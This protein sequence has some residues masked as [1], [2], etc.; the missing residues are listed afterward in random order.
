MSEISGTPTRPPFIPKFFSTVTTAAN[1]VLEVGSLTDDV[2]SAGLTGH[3]SLN[4][5]LDIFHAT[6][7]TAGDANAF[8][9]AATGE[10]P[11]SIT[12]LMNGIKV[13]QVEGGG[14]TRYFRTFLF[15][16]DGHGLTVG[17]GTTAAELKAG[18]K[19]TGGSIVLDVFGESREIVLKDTDARIHRISAGYSDGG[20]TTLMIDGST[21]NLDGGTLHFLAD[22]KSNADTNLEVGDEI[23]MPAGVRGEITNV[24]LV[25]WAYHYVLDE[26]N[27]IVYTQQTLQ[28]TPVNLSSATSKSL[29]GL[30]RDGGNPS[31]TDEFSSAVKVNPTTLSLTGSLSS[32][33][34]IPRKIS[35]IVL[36]AS[37]SHVEIQFG[38]K[39]K[40]RYSSAGGDYTDAQSIIVP[41]DTQTY[42]PLNTGEFVDFKAKSG[43]SSD[44]LYWHFVR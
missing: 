43:T 36:F 34:V 10:A 1:A 20:Y 27:I 9:S 39:Q 7:T 16:R 31:G 38:R 44:T 8:K 17:G 26:D 22:I 6:I 32:I 4:A 40:G 18:T 37:A 3:A 2:I 11:S 33:Q 28:G 35:G 21:T 5:A 13:Y 30:G 15:S 23:Y 25:G 41:Q 12:N 29:V 14:T 24:S 42:I 19:D